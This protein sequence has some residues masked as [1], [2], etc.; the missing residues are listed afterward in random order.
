MLYTYTAVITEEN[1]TFYVKGPDVNGCF[2]TVPSLTEA[3][4]LVD[5]YTDHYSGRYY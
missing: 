1:G 4:A 2:I 3:I 5:R